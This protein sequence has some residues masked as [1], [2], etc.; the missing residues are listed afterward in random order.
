MRRQVGAGGLEEPGKVL[1]TDHRPATAEPK[2]CPPCS[3]Q[4]EFSRHTVD[5]ILNPCLSP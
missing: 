4:T 2:Y 1:P 3:Y 5:H